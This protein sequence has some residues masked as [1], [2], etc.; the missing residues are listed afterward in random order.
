MKSRHIWTCLINSGGSAKKKKREEKGKERT[1]IQWR[2]TERRVKRKANGQQG[3]GKLWGTALVMGMNGER[4][5][6]YKAAV[7]HLWMDAHKRVYPRRPRALPTS[8]RPTRSPEKA[9]SDP[10]SPTPLHPASISTCVSGWR[11]QLPLPR[12]LTGGVNNV[13]SQKHS[14]TAGSPQYSKHVDSD[15]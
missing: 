7:L 10:A 1:G 3:E 8:H 13:W 9:S 14:A 4:S 15:G 11:E 12:L 2:R 6:E 5:L